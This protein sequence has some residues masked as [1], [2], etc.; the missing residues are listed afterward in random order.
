LLNIQS[1]LIGLDIF[2]DTLPIVRMLPDPLRL[3]VLVLII[4]TLYFFHF[5]KDQPLISFTRNQK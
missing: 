2:E 5:F 3:H 1:E 4:Q